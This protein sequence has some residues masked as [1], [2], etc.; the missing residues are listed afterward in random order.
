MAHCGSVMV[1]V[2]VHIK[3]HCGS[4]HTSVA[5]NPEC[6]RCTVLFMQRLEACFWDEIKYEFLQPICLGITVPVD[7]D[8]IS[9]LW[10]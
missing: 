3:N 7:I 9:S 1:R 6:N 5:E 10:K 8:V 4:L 2:S